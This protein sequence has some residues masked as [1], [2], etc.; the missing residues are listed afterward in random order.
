[1]IFSVTDRP[2][3]RPLAV[4]AA[5]SCTLASVASCALARCDNS[6]GDIANAA[7][8]AAAPFKKSRRLRR[9]GKN[10]LFI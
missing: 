5:T 2:S 7:A 6:A 8:P 9:P 1:M 4:L 10:F 3:A